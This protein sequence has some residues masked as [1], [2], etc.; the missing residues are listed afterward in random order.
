MPSNIRLLPTFIAGY[1]ILET[2][3]SELAAHIYDRINASQKTI[4]FFANTN[5]TVKCRFLLSRLI[6]TDVVIVN[7]GIG[8]DIACKMMHG[9][10]FKSNLNGTDF[11]PYFLSQSKQQ[12]R[13]FLVG[14][15]VASL[16][17]AAYY[18]VHTL[19]HIIVGSCDG[20]DGMKKTGDLVGVINES[21]AD[22]VLV[23]LGNPKQEEWILM[24]YA[25]IN[26]QFFSGVGALFDFW[27]GDKPR[28][29]HWIQGIHME[30]FYR[31][32]LEPKRLF[33]RYTIDILKFLF[34][35][36]RYRKL[37]VK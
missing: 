11:T 7:D 37:G 8:M 36:V 32:S 14:G 16:N 24:N 9:H 1:P 17:G 35:C 27:S 12:L 29:P 34:D 20:F 15:S 21:A 4:L 28:A 2:T 18:I 13:V 6:S 5:F 31:L 19:G 30:W 25:K 22:V 10:K 33:K 26:A 3:Q 23:A